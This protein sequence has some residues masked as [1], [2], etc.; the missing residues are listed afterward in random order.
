[1]SA[2]PV[3]VLLG[4]ITETTSSD[5]SWPLTVNT[6]EPPFSAV[7]TVGGLQPHSATGLAA[8]HLPIG[9]YVRSPLSPPNPRAADLT[10]PSA[11]ARS[12]ARADQDRPALGLCETTGPGGGSDPPAVAYVYAASQPIAH[13]AGF[14]GV[15]QVDGYAGYRALAEKGDVSLAF[16]WAHLRRRFYERFVSEASPIA[17]EA[18]THRRAL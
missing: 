4:T 11:G 10:E 6:P 5:Q 17:T 7:S 16:C 9:S 8:V 18:G 1:M 12:R 2:A 13:L 14:K 15:L 3:Y